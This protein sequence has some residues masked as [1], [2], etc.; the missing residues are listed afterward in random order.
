[1]NEIPTAATPPAA[2]TPEQLLRLPATLAR[3][4]LGRSA[5]LDLVKAGRAPQPVKIGRA[6]AWLASEV[7]AWIAERVRDSRQRRA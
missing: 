5:W 6:S 7:A 2:G 4:G 3:V 1:M